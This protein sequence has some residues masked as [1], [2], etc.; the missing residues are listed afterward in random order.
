[1][2][3]WG[4]GEG[5]EVGGGRGGGGGAG[6]EVGE[7]IREARGVGKEARE[8]ERTCG[9]GVGETGVEV[10]VEVGE[11]GSS[12][13]GGGP[14]PGGRVARRGGGSAAGGGAAA[15]SPCAFPLAL[16]LCAFLTRR[17]APPPHASFPTPPDPRAPRSGYVAWVTA[18]F[19]PFWGFQEGLWS[20]LSGV[21][22]NSLYPVMLAA[23][24]E[25][26][27]PQL[28]SGWPRM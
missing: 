16:S 4:W 22:D 10:E 6:E 18:A 19:G 24:L 1:M 9:K 14:G 5:G 27:F 8:E 7:E 2:G 15:L 20:W 13:G 3:R 11:R 23:N 28:E 26:F 17:H 25:I 12:A 21:T